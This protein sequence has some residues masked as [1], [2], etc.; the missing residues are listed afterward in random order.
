MKE[1][2]TDEYNRKW[3]TEWDQMKVH[4]PYA[5]HLRRI[6][7]AIIQSLQFET[8]LDVGCGQG[9]LL[10]D[11]HNIF[12]QISLCGTDFSLTSIAQAR[13]RLPHGEF[14]VMD[15]TRTALNRKFDLVVCTDV[16]EHIEDDITALSNLARMTNSYVL[17]ATIQGRMRS[18]EP[19]AWGHVRN[20][21]Y[22]ELAQKMQQVGLRVVRSVEWGFPFFSPLYRDVNYLLGG[23]GTGGQYGVLRKTLAQLIYQVFRLNSHACGDEIFILAEPVS[24]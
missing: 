6:T 18:H 4:G 11:L 13:Q 9:S 14:L 7:L 3:A 17:I 22:G 8:V 5:R 23:R 15:V 12:P 2:S 19:E 21:A 16:L 20:Y 10:A 1:M 24:R